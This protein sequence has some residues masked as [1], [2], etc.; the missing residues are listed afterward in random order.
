[1]VM[2]G[3]ILPTHFPCRRSIFACALLNSQPM[4]FYQPA[5]LVQDCRR[6]GV[7]VLPAD[8]R[9]SGWDS[10]LECWQGQAAVR[11]GLRQVKGMRQQ[12]A[13]RIEQQR[14][15]SPFNHAQDLPSYIRTYSRH[16]KSR[17]N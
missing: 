2:S 12:A 17:K 4:G 5:Q 1:M 15:Q 13:L 7:R 8:V 9:Y 11:L 16:L 14:E 10:S 3:R 6:H